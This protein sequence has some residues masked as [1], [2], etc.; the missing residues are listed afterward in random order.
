MPGNKDELFRQEQ[1]LVPDFDFSDKT[2]E[3][4][5]DMLYR[6]VPCV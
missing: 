1:E 5:D 2:A 6:S 3:V 4:F